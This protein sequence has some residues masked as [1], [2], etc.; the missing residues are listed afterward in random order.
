M[1]CKSSSIRVWIRRMDHGSL[2]IRQLEH[3]RTDELAS[4]A[5]LEV[6]CHHYDFLEAKSH[7]ILPTFFESYLYARICT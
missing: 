3:R 7:C 1:E 5:T 6:S 4:R 2:F